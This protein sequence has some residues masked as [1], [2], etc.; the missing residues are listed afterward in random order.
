M[1]RSTWSNRG[2]LPNSRMLATDS[3]SGGPARIAVAALVLLSCATDGVCQ[4]GGRYGHSVSL[5][6]DS[7]T[8]SL[9]D[10]AS[11]RDWVARDL[12]QRLGLASSDELEPDAR[13][14]QMVDT[15][16][17]TIRQQANGLP[18]VKLES[19][20]TSDQ[21]GQPIRLLGHHRAFSVPPSPAPSVVLADILKPLGIS[22]GDLSSQRLVY[23]PDG[24]RLRLSYEI[25]G[26]LG[27][28]SSGSERI[29]VDAHFGEMLER[30]PLDYHALDRR[31][32][33]L[34][35]ACRSA[36]IRSLVNDRRSARL[37]TMALRRHLVRNE[38]S[39]SGRNPSADKLFGLF[40]SFYEFLQQTLEMDSFDDAGGAFNGIVDA[41]FHAEKRSPQCVG[42]Q[43]NALW[44]SPLRSVVLSGAAVEFSEMVGHELGHGLID[45]GSRLIYQGES[46]ALNESIADSIGVAFR[47]WLETKGRLSSRLPADIWRI[48]GPAGPLRDMSNPQRVS[49]LPNHYSDYRF[50]RTDVDHGGV[51]INSSIM[52]QGFYLLAMGGRHPNIDTGP[53]VSGIGMAKALE[54]FGRAAFNI[55]TPISNFTDAREAFAHTAEILHGKESPEWV[56]THTA[57]DAI[58]IPGYWKRPSVPSPSPVV[59]DD[60]VPEK[61]TDLES[62]P[63]P[64]DPS[65]TQSQ[66]DPT[67]DPVDDPAEAPAPQNDPIPLP[68]TNSPSPTQAE[69]ES[70]AKQD[71]V[72]TTTPRNPSPVGTGSDPPLPRNKPNA[73]E[74]V[75]TIVAAVILLLAVTLAIAKARANRRTANWRPPT[76]DAAAQAP[77]TAAAAKG[78]IRRVEGHAPSPLVSRETAG[79]LVPLD[80]S[81]PIPL[82]LDLLRSPVG[83]VIGRASEL[84]DVRIP[85]I[86]VSRRHL[87]CRLDNGTVWIE[88]LNST[89]RT[90][91][92]GKQ[93]EKFTPMAVSHGQLVRIGKHSYAL[94]ID[95]CGKEEPS[96]L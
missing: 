27:D 46:G 69:T 90:E 82:P 84:C 72:T 26:V 3:P 77:R 40:G 61:L 39:G 47:G 31:I 20:L 63:E 8:V 18:V 37:V 22:E 10:D 17:Y 95:G 67:P 57:M 29:Y 7:E 65:D 59:D 51:H 86:D 54:I 6:L 94:S 79:A 50:L 38:T 16:I 75:P 73:P 76:S 55:L 42:D 19:R 11:L 33:D 45:S 88:D 78:P 28:Q 14:R 49:G 1:F 9:L 44:I 87:R 13:P 48:R 35:R 89:N 4:E 83:L 93:M 25:E 70:T 58:G 36:R 81:K 91:I 68:E 53:E 64:A 43:F 66:S 52:N 85:D 41:R 23:W 92:D 2:R 71:P 15:S 80:G 74:L 24:S 30:L 12:H 60:P 56:A 21:S 62:E 96:T 5:E 34:E 32:Y